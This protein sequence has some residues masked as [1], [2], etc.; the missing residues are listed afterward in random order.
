M[1]L[2]IAVLIMAFVVLLVLVLLIVPVKACLIR[3]AREAAQNSVGI[4]RPIPMTP[5]E[6]PP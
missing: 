1:V 2:L 6:R 3:L 5:A 4:S